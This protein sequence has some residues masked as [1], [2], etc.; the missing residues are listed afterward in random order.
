MCPNDFRMIIGFTNGCFDCFHEG[1]LHFINKCLQIAEFLV[2]AV[3]N[4][5]SVALLK[6]KGRPKKDLFSR[7]IPITQYRD[8]GRRKSIGIPFGGDPKPLLQAIKP[9]ILFRGEDQTITDF[10]RA[11]F[12]DRIVV[13]PRLPGFSTTEELAKL[14]A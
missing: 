13:I 12:G 8:F 7:L 1:H 2:V 4:D 10:E 14:R 6:G 3:N 11:M 5:E 9:D